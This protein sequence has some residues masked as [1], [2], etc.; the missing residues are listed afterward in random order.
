M[1]EGLMAPPKPVQQQAA[2]PSEPAS[3][4]EEL[5]ATGLNKIAS[6][7]KGQFGEELPIYASG[8][9][10][11][12]PVNSSPLSV[13]ERFKLSLGDE[14]GNYDF[15]KNKFKKVVQNKNGDFTVLDEDGRW[16]RVDPDGNDGDA[17]EFTKDLVEMVPTAGKLG[18]SVAAGLLTGGSSLAVQAGVLGAVG[19]ASSLAQTS[20]G[21][22]VGTYSD[23]PV[24]QVKDMALETILNAGGAIIPAGAKY[25]AEKLPSLIGKSFSKLGE[26]APNA[27]DAFFSTMSTFTGVADDAFHTTA[28]NADEVANVLSGAL[29]GRNTTQA[30]EYIKSSMFT[31]TKRMLNEV[32]DGVGQLYEKLLARSLDAVPED[33]VI[34][35]MDTLQKRF[36]DVLVKRGIGTV[37]GEGA[38]VLKNTQ[39]VWDELSRA[40]GKMAEGLGLNKDE[41]FDLMYKINQNMGSMSK[42]NFLKGRAGYEKLI[43]I[44]KEIKLVQRQLAGIAE[45]TNNSGL[46]GLVKDIGSITDDIFAK[47]YDLGVHVDMTKHWG[48]EMVNALKGLESTTGEQL[49]SSA[50][51]TRN[52]WLAVKR[53]YDMAEDA[54]AIPRQAVAMGQNT[55]AVEGVMNML[56]STSKTRIAPRTSFESI[57]GVLEQAKGWRYGNMLNQAA[58]SIP[59]T[60]KQLKIHNAAAAFTP[61]ARPGLV[62]T[63]AGLGA[64]ASGL[65]AIASEDNRGALGTVA[66]GLATTAA[67]SSPRLAYTAVKSFMAARGLIGQLIA[68][69]GKDA[70]VKTASTTPGLMDEFVGTLASAPGSHASILNNAVS[71][72]NNFALKMDPAK[73]SQMAQ[74]RIINGPK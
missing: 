68:K 67:L 7:A 45:K 53:M 34:T 60:A 27:R 16:K 37:N 3:Y 63:Q 14:Q 9:S 5:A 39:Q 64:A 72:A 30:A 69:G 33:K 17:W 8:L 50:G 20:M 18:A 55:S 52:P 1:S 73:L 65:G 58:E 4:D 47:N 21:R 62:S 66:G 26:M 32:S 23:D 74:K 71:Q 43:G 36:Q 25:G 56:G 41:M 35:G 19:A 44:D 57:V 15:L 2:A 54:T 12:T 24:A 59:A 40:G 46:V 38:F 48:P 28:S 13:A 31:S 61:W 22:L 29:K 6:V 42:A 70:F 11:V 51:T 49:L 10:P